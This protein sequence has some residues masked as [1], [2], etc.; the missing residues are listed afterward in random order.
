MRRE[1]SQD[2]PMTKT[3]PFFP[4]KRLGQHFLKNPQ[5]IQDILTKARFEENA[6][7]L[8]VGPGLGALTLPPAERVNRVIGVEKDPRLAEML[9]KRLS[10]EKISNVILINADILKLDFVQIPGSGTAPFHVIGNLPY[11][12]S[13]PFVEKLISHRTRVRRA[14]LTFQLELARRLAAVPGNKDYGSLTIL[15]QYYARITPLLEISREA[16]FPKPEVASMVL[17]MDFTRPYPKRAE[18][19]ETFRKV[20]KA[21]F[22]QRRKTVLN[23]LRGSLTSLGREPIM[24]ALEKCG[25]DPGNRAEDLHMDDYLC[26]CTLLKPGP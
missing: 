7:V 26:L 22:S 3:T 13:S 8:E 1:P 24:A 4:R 20:V 5:I 19:E 11:N 10:L 23:S 6:E 15:I 21:A 14:I 16:F 18:D 12:I 9:R 17:E 25:I 2:K